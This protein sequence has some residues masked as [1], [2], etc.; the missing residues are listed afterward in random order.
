MVS[1]IFTLYTESIVSHFFHPLA[2]TESMSNA[3]SFQAAPIEQDSGECVVADSDN[4]EQEV[5]I[6]TY[7]IAK[8]VTEPDEQD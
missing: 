3:E 1:F 6:G 5:D 8:T 4:V 7:N 2:C